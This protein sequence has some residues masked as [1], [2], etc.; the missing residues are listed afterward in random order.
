MIAKGW[1][2]MGNQ[3]LDQFL[4]IFYRVDNWCDGMTQ[5]DEGVIKRGDFWSVLACP[6]VTIC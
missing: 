2:G 4:R 3:P 1:C 5:R 6:A